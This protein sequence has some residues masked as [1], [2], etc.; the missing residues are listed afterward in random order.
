[1]RLRLVALVAIPTLAALVAGTNEYLVALDDKRD[2]VATG[3]LF[4]QTMAGLA[5]VHE[6]QKERGMSAGHL[7]S[8]GAKF[9]DELRRQRVLTDNAVEAYRSLSQTINEESAYPRYRQNQIAALTSFNQLNEM[10]A[11]VDALNISV[12]DEL[13]F[14]TDIN[15]RLLANVRQFGEAS[16]NAVLAQKAMALA[17]F[18]SSKERAGIERAV[19][20]VTF[21]LDRFTEQ[22]RARLERLIYEQETFLELF[23]ES[24]VEEERDRFALAELH[25]AYT[26][27]QEMRDQAFAKGAN[28]G[29]D[30][31][32]WWDMI[33]A[34]INQLREVEQYLVQSLTDAAASGVERANHT[35][36]VLL[37]ALAGFL[38]CTGLLAGLIIRQ[39]RRQLGAE[40]E[41]LVEF[42]QGIAEG[43]ERSHAF[44]QIASTGVLASMQTMR[45]ILK[46]K[47]DKEAEQRHAV[48][49]LVRAVDR[50]STPVVVACPDGQI[51]NANRAFSEYCSNYGDSLEAAVPDFN[52]SAIES[53]SI[54]S[55]FPDLRHVAV[56]EST[57][58]R[59]V[60]LH[61]RFVELTGNR[62]VDEA[63]QIIG[64]V[65]E[66]L[67]L[68]DDRRVVDEVSTA[69]ARAANGDLTARVC[70]DNKTGVIKKLTDEINNL[71]TVTESV[72]NAL[73]QSLSALAEGDLSRPAASGHHG[74]FG[75]VL[76]AVDETS[77]KLRVV[78]ESIKA[79]A[80]SVG[81]A[82]VDI[83]EGSNRLQVR[84]ERASAGIE[85][86]ATNVNN[87]SKGL[88]ENTKLIGDA[89]SVVEQARVNAEQGDRVVKSAVDAMSDITASSEKIA[90]IIDVI[91][92]I[93]F[94]T[95]LLAL[96]ASVEAARAGEHGR[97]FAVVAS[98]VRSLAQRS[99]DS[100]REIRNIIESSRGDVARGAELVQETGDTLQRIVGSVK[101]MEHI[102][103]DIARG[104]E[105]QRDR[106]QTI[107]QELE[108]LDQD[109]RANTQLARDM[110]GN[111]ERTVAEIGALME[112]TSFFNLGD[113]A[114]SA[115]SDSVLRAAS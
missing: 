43:D 91:N 77:Q 6:I 99:A 76:S 67:D 65:L 78:V 85:T 1:M 58:R 56:G 93:S 12:P 89:E 48:M 20:S 75:V 47:A 68:T 73:A 31:T 21:N 8:D 59:R 44:D 4:E 104:S 30:S 62:V 100:A 2:A 45:G 83:E 70:T 64:M 14:Y 34:K 22:Y 23:R 105:T 114:R 84:T 95:N 108:S 13:R 28:F 90:T 39:M 106:T 63:G 115:E 33:T 109:K 7:S 94:Q 38:A 81:R 5:A 87:I 42:A 113:A 29:V 53:Q 110:L 61:D 98:E 15:A 88:C 32:V 27:T 46:D 16:G 51:L 80:D 26:R 96:N 97:G 92:E 60:P 52:Y 24:A 40:P 79:T 74:T 86:A 11:S 112:A 49:R 10:R 17:F 71:L 41:Q 37:G 55:F 103:D 107:S 35:V 57:I 50:I 3:L 69:I 111:A 9:A 18:A 19:F 101:S 72:T 66:V 36:L 54:F 82:A 25:P 102:F